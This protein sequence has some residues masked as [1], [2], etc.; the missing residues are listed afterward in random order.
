MDL[1]KNLLFFALGLM[2][3]TS[4]SLQAMAEEQ[5]RVSS[6]K[7]KRHLLRLKKNYFTVQNN[8]HYTTK[9][10]DNI[11]NDSFIKPVCLGAIKEYTLFN[12]TIEP[13]LTEQKLYA[14][15]TKNELVP[16]ATQYHRMSRS[17]PTMMR[18]WY[19]FPKGMDQN[20]KQKLDLLTLIDA[21]HAQACYLKKV[22]IDTGETEFIE[23]KNL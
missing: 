11:E 19:S 7:E 18:T 5:K 21:E 13:G 12:R 15:T 23:L 14:I 3:Y 20:L 4:S 17:N 9:S 22:D 1:K 2:T 10:Y 6:P 8:L 16:L